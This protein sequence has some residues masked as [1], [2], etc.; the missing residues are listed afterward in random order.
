MKLRE[1]LFK[2]FTG[3]SNHGCVITGK[4]KGMGT[5]GPCGCLHDLS[6]T[7]IHI[8]KSR[9]ESIAEQEI[10]VKSGNDNKLQ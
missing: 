8:L 5:N 6:R 9:I 3:C 7:Q 1:Y 4:R 2:D 10:D